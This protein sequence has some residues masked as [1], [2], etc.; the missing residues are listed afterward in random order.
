M[1]TPPSE[2]NSEMEVRLIAL[3]DEL[4]LSAFVAEGCCCQV[5][6]LGAS[7]SSVGLAPIVITVGGILVQVRQG[8]DKLE[9]KLLFKRE[10]RF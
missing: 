4:K 10:V 2:G 8:G 7:D 6:V 5:D 3:T 9:D 1:V